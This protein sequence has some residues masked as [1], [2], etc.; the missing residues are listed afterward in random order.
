LPQID[1]TTGR[2]ELDEMEARD[3]ETYKEDKWYSKVS[4]IL[5]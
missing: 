2:L 3:Q 4:G 5:F 1:F